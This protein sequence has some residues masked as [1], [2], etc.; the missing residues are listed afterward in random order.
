METLMQ[1]AGL[2]VTKEVLVRIGWSGYADVSDDTLYVFMRALR[3]KIQFE[4]QPV[5]LHT[6]RGVGYMLKAVAADA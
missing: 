5:L 4:R 3:S 6:I 1:R 2:V